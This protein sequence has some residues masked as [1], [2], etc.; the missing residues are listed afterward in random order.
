MFHSIRIFKFCALPNRREKPLADRRMLGK[1]IGVTNTDQLV[2]KKNKIIQSK[3]QAPAE[4]GYLPSKVTAGKTS[5]LRPAA[6]SG[7]KGAISQKTKVIQ[8]PA[9]TGRRAE[10]P[11]EEI[12]LRAYFISERR[13]RLALPGDAESDWLEAKRQLLSESG[14]R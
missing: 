11:E 8:M 9:E 5:R 4:A 2:P 13:R 1:R 10:P 14:L 7:K 3:I 6:T 12:R